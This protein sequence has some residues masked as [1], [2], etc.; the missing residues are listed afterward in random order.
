M[1]VSAWR[2]LDHILLTSW[3]WSGKNRWLTRQR[4][5]GDSS[6]KQTTGKGKKRER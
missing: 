1:I 3:K 5:P 6:P 4:S 2:M